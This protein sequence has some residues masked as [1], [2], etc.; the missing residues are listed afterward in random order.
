MHRPKIN[1][2]RYKKHE[3]NHAKTHHNQIAQKHEET[4]EEPEECVTEGGMKRMTDSCLK[5]CK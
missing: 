4:Y 1:D 3:E 5:Q 2:A